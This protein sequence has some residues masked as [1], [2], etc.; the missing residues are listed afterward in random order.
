MNIIAHNITAMNAQRQYGTNVSNKQASMEKLSSGY[1]INRAADDAAGLSISEKMRWQVRG[2]SKGSNN[3]QDGISL[4]QVADGALSEVEDMLHRMSELSIQAANDTNTS[5]DR[6][7]IQS[8]IDQISSEIT[9]IGKT[10]TFNTVHIF[11]EDNTKVNIGSVTQLVS[12]Y[13]ADIGY[14]SEAYYM[15][16]DY[17][18]AAY[19]DFSNLNPSNMANINGGSFGFCCS[20]NC[21]EIFDISLYTDGTPS[22]C[23]NLSGKVEHKYSVD[24]SGC[25]NGADVV[26]AI[27]DYVANNLPNNYTATSTGDLKVSHS[28]NL[29]K[30]ADGTKLIIY[31]NSYSFS[32]EQSAKDKYVGVK[33]N[34]GKIY[35]NDLTGVRDSGGARAFNI[36]CSSNVGDYE[37]IRT[38][39]MNAELLGVDKLNVTTETTAQRAIQKV[40]DAVDMISSQRSELGAYQNRLEHSQ[41]NDNV[42]KENV[43]AAE[44]RIRDVD[45]ATEAVE[46]SK[47]SILAQVG[48]AMMTQANQSSQGILALLQ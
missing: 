17:Y 5:E 19:M 31:S 39:K 9:R 37:V 46:L 43:Q 3:I 4:M 13:S 14:L 6:C 40:A 44:S 47:N 28:N 15:N 32:S 27:Y 7:A 23:S 33:N 24:I 29:A 42:M 2:L 20:Q 8:E 16:G 21:N 18:P 41:A 36:Q 10:T 35:S 48:E 12:C 1:R 26:N 38:H 25:Q 45:M 22:S 30:S 34:S 11:D